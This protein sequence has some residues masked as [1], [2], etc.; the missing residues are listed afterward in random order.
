[1]A[2]KIINGVEYPL[3]E[4]EE[5]AR[6]AESDAWDL[7][8][9]DTRMNRNHILKVT[10]IVL[11]EDFPLSAGT[12]EEWLAY[13]QELRDCLDSFERVSTFEFPKSPIIKKAGEDAY[14]AKKASGPSDAE[15][16]ERGGQEAWDALTDEEKES[17]TERLA[18]NEKQSA[19]TVAG[20]PG[21]GIDPV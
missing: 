13:R 12:K 21:A 20:Y 6:I 10:D 8:I 5:A 3:T 7:R 11:L 14:N 9:D 16:E 4:E 2:I 19:E 18:L 15:K 17:E 1:M